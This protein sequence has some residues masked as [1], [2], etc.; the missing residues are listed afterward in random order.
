MA[1]VTAYVGFIGLGKMGRPMALNLVKG[2]MHVKAYDLNPQALSGLESSGIEVVDSA[3][4][5]VDGVDFVVSMLP[6]S[7][8]VQMLYLGTNGILEE[9]HEQ[10]I[11]V[12]CSTIAPQMTRHL[13]ARAAQRG[14]RILDAP[15]S[16]GTAAAADGTL[17]FIVGGTQRVLDAC[18]PLLE[19]MGINIM[20]AGGTGAGQIA[21]ICNNMLL[22][23]LM[24]GTAEALQLG[25]ANGLDPVRLTEIIKA[26]SGNNWALNLYNPYPGVMEDT[27]ASRGYE[28]GFMVDH[29]TKDLR[30][31]MGVAKDSDCIAPM[32]GRARDLYLTLK[33]ADTDYSHKDFS[34]IQYLYSPELASSS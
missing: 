9:I 26:S 21:K 13:A 1:N 3:R 12:D 22:A 18:R 33:K 31:A 7:L 29:M 34:V 20:H 30:L 25:V 32:G 11:I 15:V 6:D 14:I 16:G 5:A 27:P 19:L 10:S 24:T 2:G 8:Q 28:G 23:V 4:A 17:T